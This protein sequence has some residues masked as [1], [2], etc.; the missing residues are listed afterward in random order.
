MTFGVQL[1][2]Q[3]PRAEADAAW[4]LPQNEARTTQAGAC[5]RR[6][7]E[8]LEKLLRDDAVSLPNRLAFLALENELFHDQHEGTRS[9]M[10]GV[11]ESKL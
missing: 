10:E 5:N 1:Y 3:G 11:P 9:L 8:R 7:A 6:D 4:R 2:G